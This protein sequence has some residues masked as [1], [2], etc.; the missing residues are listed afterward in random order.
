[1]AARDRERPDAAGSRQDGGDIRGTGVPA[2][3]AGAPFPPLGYVIGYLERDP[4]SGA[5]RVPQHSW[6]DIQAM[7][8]FRAVAERCRAVPAPDGFDQPRRRQILACGAEPSDAGSRGAGPARDRPWR[9][10]PTPPGW[11]GGPDQGERADLPRAGR[12]DYATAEATALDG[13]GSWAE[14]WLWRFCL[15]VTVALIVYMI[16]ASF[17]EAGEPS[18]VAVG[19]D[20]TRLTLAASGFREGWTSVGSIPA[21]PIGGSVFVPL[22]PAGAQPAPLTLAGPLP[23]R[24]ISR[25]RYTVDQRILAGPE[26]A[27]STRTVFFEESRQ[28]TPK[29]PPAV[30]SSAAW[31]QPSMPRSSLRSIR[32]H[33]PVYWQPSSCCR[34]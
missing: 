25:A 2:P 11:L 19:Q 4:A 5:L 26:V 15:I 13:G 7:R 12:Q 34:W 23:T 6:D 1:M 14:G 24:V 16:F 9:T 33:P 3:Q 10:S 28:W 17:V 30:F 20:P 8:E 22:I 32:R 18:L 29:F 21:P 31:P 27:T